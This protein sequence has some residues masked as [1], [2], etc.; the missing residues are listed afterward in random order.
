ML[1]PEE[2]GGLWT[3]T[4]R[5]K[6]RS[7]QLSAVVVCLLPV[8]LDRLSKGSRVSPGN[9]IHGAI[10]ACAT[11]FGTSILFRVRLR[12]PCVRRLEVELVA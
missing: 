2:R 9:G 7:V 4:A 12:D 5:A 6:T 3:N 10:V 8:I 1:R 11:L